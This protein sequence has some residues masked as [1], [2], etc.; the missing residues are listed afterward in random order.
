MMVPRVL[1]LSIVFASIFC[2][3]EPRRAAAQEAGA[4]ASSGT[5]PAAAPAFVEPMNAPHWNGWG[6]DSSQHRFQ[7]AAMAQI[8]AEDV[9]R[10]KLKWAFGFP[11]ATRTFAQPT[12]VGGLLF[13]GSQSGTVYALD[14]KSGCTYWKFD[15][16]AGVR[17]SVTIGQT[18]AGW[19][20]YFGDLKATVHAVDAL[21]GT[22]LWKIR[23]DDHPVAVVT[24]SP[25]LVGTTLF[26][27]VSSYE[28][29][30]GADSEYACCKFRGS[31]VALDAATGRSLWKSYTISEEPKPTAMN[32][33]GVQS[34]GPSG[35]GVWS[36]PTFDPDKGV[37]YAT[38]G[39]N[40]SDP[41]TDTSDAFLAFDAA[42]GR[43]V[44]SRQVTSDDAYTIACNGKEPGPNCPK[45]NGP[46]F[47]FGSSAI[48]VS[49]PNGK[50]ALVAGQKSGVVTA[51]DPDRGGEVLWQAHVGHGGALGGVEWG[52]AADNDKVYVAVSDTKIN[53]VSP[54]WP[55][56]QPSIF[57]PKIGWLLNS[58]TG[59]G[60]HALKL[61]TG[62]EA[63]NTPHP[64]CNNVPG[65]GPAQSAAVTAIPGIVFS[66]G[67]DGHLRAY[68]ADNGR[69][70]WDVDTKGEYRTVNGVAGRGG[71]IDG[72][73]AVAVGGMLYAG[74]GSGIWGGS[75]G[76]VLLAY[77][78]DGH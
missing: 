70:V 47:D 51:V 66:G 56:A 25:T 29:A 8:A 32:S 36:S 52:S 76:N 2:A 20:A 71:S 49:L 43:R 74:S 54:D 35:A 24:G 63:W 61:E 67:L 78:V 6:V 27:P 50:R 21:T 77:S 18:S 23:V 59:G 17:S 75:P 72:P 26:V 40:Y 14:A 9:A 39:D 5:C 28:E 12:V 4:S 34:M 22:P 31:I 57:N 62:E 60:L 53:V 65:C 15:A 33:V 38:T 7:P 16:R 11:G 44:W 30:T 68:S 58:S 41:P 55:G 1:T 42:S 37:I 64:G 73:G 48:L 13:V 19:A 46:D 10:L 69:I 3:T 45:A